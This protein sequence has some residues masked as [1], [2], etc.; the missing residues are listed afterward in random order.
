MNEWVWSIFRIILT[1]KNQN[2]QRETWPSALHPPQIPYGLAYKGTQV[3]VVRGPGLTVRA[4][5][6]RW[7]KWPKNV[8]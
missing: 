4:I 1:G 8:L 3:S 2:I 6:L 5:Y 7:E